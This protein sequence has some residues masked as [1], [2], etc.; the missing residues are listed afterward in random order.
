MIDK[1]V[2]TVNTDLI[3]MSNSLL[4]MIF[5][6][7]KKS[8][9]VSGIH[10]TKKEDKSDKKQKEYT[11]YP[12]KYNFQKILLF[13]SSFPDFP[14]YP[15]MKYTLTRSHR[16]TVAIQIKRD[17]EIYVK[18]P[19]FVPIAQLEKF[20]SEKSDW[21]SKKQSEQIQRKRI[22]YTD[23]EIKEQKQRLK[24]YLDE[25]VYVLWKKHILPPYT[26]IKITKSE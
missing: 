11:E 21:I 17:G 23:T 6:V 14:Y 1:P 22:I 7:S 8:T 24:T 19:F 10:K 12:E 26:S 25:Q 16:K 13:I 2:N 4:I 9:E 20:L 15:C 18:A 5:S 3:Q